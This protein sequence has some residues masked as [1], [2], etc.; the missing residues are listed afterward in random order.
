MISHFFRPSVAMMVA[1]VT[2]RLVEIVKPR[3][4]SRVKRDFLFTHF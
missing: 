1:M 3:V 2:P 4:S